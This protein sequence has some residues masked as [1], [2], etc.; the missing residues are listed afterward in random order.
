MEFGPTFLN[1]FR[2]SVDSIVER[3][4][5]ESSSTRAASAL[6]GAIENEQSVIQVLSHHPNGASGV[7]DDLVR[8]AA[9]FV[10]NA[11]SSARDLSSF[12]RVLLLHQID[13]MW[14]GDRTEYESSSS[15]L[16]APELE[17]LDALNAAGAL[18]FRYRRHATT[19]VRRIARGISR[20]LPY[21]GSP[22]GAGLRYPRA[23]PELVE[24]L[25]QIAEDFDATCDRFGLDRRGGVWV[26]SVTRSVAHQR[27]LRSLGYSAL[28]PSAHCSGYAADIA[29]SWLQ[30]TGG[31]EAL[32]DVLLRRRDRGEVNVI[33]EGAAW[34]ICPAPEAT[35]DLRTAFALRVGK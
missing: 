14:W 6:A 22:P 12:V 18:Q 5:E 20:R 15:V 26:N 16:D 3:L 33:D 25:N 10:P 4:E 30:P 8:E 35:A 28:R 7:I 21:A 17:D 13:V 9:E 34:H 23:R 29:V 2:R 24:L 27:H 32:K 11:R 1:E 19:A 31:D